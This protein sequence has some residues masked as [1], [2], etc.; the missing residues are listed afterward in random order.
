MTANLAQAI[1]VDTGTTATTISVTI[2]VGQGSTIY[3]LV[4]NDQNPGTPTI[5]VSDGTSYTAIGSAVIDPG[6]Q[7]IKAFYRPNVTAGTYTVTATYSISNLDAR[8]I[9]AI[10]AAGVIAA[11]LGANGPGN[12]Q[13]TP[14]TTTDAVTSGTVQ[15]NSSSGVLIAL[16]LLTG[17]AGAAPVAGTGFTSAGTG[18]NVASAGNQARVESK[19]VSSGNV[20][21]TFTASVNSGHCTTMAF[22]LEPSTPQSESLFF[23]AGTTS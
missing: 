13:S 20:Q 9:V 16:S 14:T 18:W 17:A 15:T 3:V 5:T 4:T 12:F 19:H 23:G 10:E 8:G 2:T 1:F 22:F 7:E 6:N 21:A 11:P